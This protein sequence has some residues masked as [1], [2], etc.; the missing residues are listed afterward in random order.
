MHSTHESLPSYRSLDAYD[1][2]ILWALDNNARQP[3]A[4]I[5]RAVGLGSDLVAY[6]FE[7][8][9]QRGIIQRC[10]AWVDPARLGYTV[11]KTYLKVEAN[12]AVVKKLLA[13][14]SHNPALYWLAEFYGH[15]SLLFTLFA[16]DPLDFQLAHD[17]LLSPYTRLILEASSATIV[18]LWRYPKNY[19]VG[20]GNA[21]FHY[22][23][24]LGDQKIDALEARII[25][26]LASDARM[27]DVAIAKKVETTPAVVKYRIQRLEEEKIIV[28]YRTQVGYEQLGVMLFKLLITLHSYNSKDELAF[29]E[30]CRKH[31]QVIVY[32]RQIG[33]WKAELEVEVSHYLELQA[34]VEELQ[35]KF[36]NLIRSIEYML[37]K[38][39]HLH[40]SPLAG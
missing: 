2:K 7:R 27:T 32:V 29:R 31:P 3:F 13:D 28:G 14:L 6:R 26:E 5:G 35:Q 37:V 39:D 19:L 24:A 33:Q 9:R 15:W 18:Q 22:C 12:D 11:Y 40:R 23:G 36:P 1:R 30:H 10:S 25:R 20:K 8:M 34:L 17:K 4:Q 16:K 21:E 38:K